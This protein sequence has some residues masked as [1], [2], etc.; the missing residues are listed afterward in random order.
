MA[1]VGHVAGRA[2]RV[3]IVS[4]LLKDEQSAT[5]LTPMRAWAIFSLTLL[6]IA[7]P[8]WTEIKQPH[9]VIDIHA[10]RADI[11]NTLIKHTPVGSSMGTVVEFVSNR[12]EITGSILDV[13][14]QPAK[15]AATLPGTKA[16]RVHLG[17]YYKRLGTVFLTAPMVMHEDVDAQW[18]FDAHS[19]LIDIVVE[20]Q[21]RVY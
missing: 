16:I 15:A 20:K 21:A 5:R 19:R 11:R 4:A 8:A 7:E 12:L 3:P 17:Q 18:L 9:V 10:T 2:H 13:S 1:L 6:S 14:I